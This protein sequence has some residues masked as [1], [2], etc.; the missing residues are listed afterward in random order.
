M[1]SRIEQQRCTPVL[2]SGLTFGSV[3]PASQVAQEWA[4]KYGYPLEDY[5]DLMKVAQF[6]QVQFDAQFPAEQIH[7]LFE[8]TVAPD[9]SDPAEPHAILARMPFKV[10]LTTNYDNFLERALEEQGRNPVRRICQWN[11]KIQKVESA[12]DYFEPTE[13]KPLVFHLYGVAEIPESLVL[14]ADDYLTYLTNLS[15]DEVRLPIAVQKVL[16]GSSLLFIGFR[17]EDPGFEILY[18]SLH[19]YL[20]RSLVSRHFYQLLPPS[21]RGERPPEQ[22]RAIEK[23]FDEYLDRRLSARA[24]W[25]TSKDF[26]NELR[27]RV[28]QWK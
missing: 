23:Y 12:D 20:E 7:R 11:T 24:Y 13:G 6:M 18:H 1:L 27:R 22:L 3:P 16:T 10:Y 2:G 26:T 25:G 28:K 14:S 8:E 19:Q 9:F 4:V 21:D 5:F 17:F 15:R